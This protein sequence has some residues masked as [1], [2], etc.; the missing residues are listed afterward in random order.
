MAQNFIEFVGEK[1]RLYRDKVFLCDF[2]TGQKLSYYEFD[3]ITHRLAYGFQKLGLKKGDHVALLHP[4]HPDFILCYTGVIKAGGVI[5]PINS[6]YTSREIGFILEDSQAKILVTTEELYQ[7]LTHDDSDMSSNDNPDTTIIK[8]ENQSLEEAIIKEIGQLMPCEPEA[9]DADHPA[10][11][12]YTS[13]TTGTPKGV[14]LTH[15]NLTFGG[16]NAAQNYG[17]RDDDITIA[18]LPLVHVFANASPVFGSLSSGGM[19]VVMKKFA[20]GSIYKAITH[21]SVTWFPGVPSMFYY[22]LSDFP[23]NEH[24]IKSLRMGLSGGAS[25]TVEAIREFE[26]KFHAKL[27]EVYGLTESTGLVTANPVFGIRKPGS[28]GIAVS[29]VEVKVIDPSGK[30]CAQGEVGELAFRGANAVAGYWN[31]P[32]ITRERIKNGWVHTGDHVYMDEDGYYF[33]V[34]REG[35]LI[36]SGGYNIYEKEIEMVLSSHPEIQEVAVIGIPDR[37]KGEIPK[38]FV[39]LKNDASLD[40]KVLQSFCRQHLAIYKVPV[41]EFMKELPKNPVGKTAKNKL[42]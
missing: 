14:I 41:I 17:L 7:R 3:E 38:A 11:I 6:V 12:F 22:L 18:V 4:N 1:A 36:I 39:V 5:V 30:A 23:S 35:E 2:E 19:V 21:Y 26:E 24:K 34:G 13:G 28:I 42:S 20:A 37:Y 32:E 8:K 16:A 15:R 33:L 29:G 25:M 9:L 10:I 40:K 31:R 27:L